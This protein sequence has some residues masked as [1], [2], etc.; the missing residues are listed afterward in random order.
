MLLLFVV[1]SLLLSSV[2]GVVLFFVLT[3]GEGDDGELEGRAGSSEYT[4]GGQLPS[5]QVLAVLPVED[6]RKPRG[7][8][9][10]ASGVS[11]KKSS[12]AS[13]DGRAALKVF[14][15]KG[16]GTSYHSGVGGVGITA[17]P[18]GFPGQ[19]LIVA[20]D[21]YFELGFDFARSGK[22]GGL[23]VGHG[24]ASGGQHSPTGASHRVTWQRKGAVASY[25][26]P[27]KDV[28][29]EDPNLKDEGSGVHYLDDKFPAGTLKLGQ[30]NRMAV[31]IKM[32]TFDGNGKPRPDGMGLLHVNGRTEFLGRI[33]WSRSRD[34]VITNFSF[35][36][37]FGGAIASPKDQTAFYTNF[38]V[39]SWS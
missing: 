12:V 11:W 33:R 14:Y 18:R 22:F 17:S 35:S 13:L 38:K 32:N 10:N 29:Q 2:A 37:F 28:P 20:F 39:M 31:G 4:F 21:A 1:C 30:W 34:L 24:A 25:I 7:G 16:S 8:V 9:W 3:G 15:G 6:L 26:Y 36:T 5:G 27:P 23:F 19:A